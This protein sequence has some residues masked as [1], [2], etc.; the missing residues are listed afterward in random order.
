MAQTNFTPISLYYSTTAST[1]P[2]AGNL[3]NGELAINITDGKLY[4]KDNAGV[5]QTIASKNGVAGGSNTQ[6]QY[7]SSG[8]L[9]GSANMTFSGTALTLAND[10]SI[11]G[12]TVGK[13][14]GALATNTVVGSGALAATNSGGYSVAVGQNAGAATTSGQIVAVGA[15]ALFTNSTGSQ[16]T[17]IGISALYAN[18]TGSNNVAV[19]TQPLFSN[20]TASNCTAVGYQAGYSNT[21]GNN[22]VMLGRLAGYSATISAQNTFIG[23][24]AGYSSNVTAGGNGYNTFVGYAAGYSSTTGYNN[25]FVG[26]NGN[27]TGAGHYVTTGIA[28]TILGA[29]NGN[30]GGLDIRTASN[31]IVLSDGDGNPRGIFDNNGNF[32]VGTTTSYGQTTSAKA[33]SY[34]YAT[35]SIGNGADHI[36]FTN[37]GTT[38]GSV[39]RVAGTGVIYN[40]T[41]DYRLKENV[42]PMVGALAK[43]KAL[44]PVT[45]TWKLDGS[46]GQGFIAHELQAIIPE[47]VSGEK[48]AV[49]EDGRI[50]PQG[51]D[52]SRIV[53][54]LTA[55]I[56]ELNAK[57]EAQALEIAA[58]KK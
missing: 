14:G 32:L 35:N 48:D 9:A 28:N 1:A 23:A 53:A 20:T 42:V 6:V 5:V 43:V 3:V 10:A 25:T 49:E 2:T 46:E 37:G 40:T 36:L 52:Q 29:Y 47:A 18:T 51:I 56:Q 27:G 19:G 7:N 33:S 11:S 30:Q 16:N 15:S 34:C 4:Y 54:T 38:V 44:K 31:Y 13:G 45:Y 12:L 50:K 55:A 57:V 21:T 17:A 8:S 22:S 58:L 24:N 39:A 41:S 26:S